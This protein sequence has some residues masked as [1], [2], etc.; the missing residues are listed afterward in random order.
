MYSCLNAFY[1]ISTYTVLYNLPQLFYI[2]YGTNYSIAQLI[3]KYADKYMLYLY[4][5]ANAT[6]NQTKTNKNEELHICRCKY[7]HKCIILNIIM[8]KCEL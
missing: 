6:E 1:K 4:V 2:H 3:S 5:Y 7:I 8:H